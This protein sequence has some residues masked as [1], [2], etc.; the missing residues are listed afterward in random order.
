MNAAM[1]LQT[2]DEDMQRGT[3]SLMRVLSAKGNLRVDNLLAMV[4]HLKKREDVSFS[5]TCNSGLHA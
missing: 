5:M 3:K 2:I 4:A 1:G